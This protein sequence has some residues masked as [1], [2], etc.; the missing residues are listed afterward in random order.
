MLDAQE[1]YSPSKWSPRLKEDVIVG[2]YVKQ[3]KCATEHARNTLECEAN[4][5]YSDDGNS[6]AMDIYYPKSYTKGTQIFMFIHGGD[7][8]EGGLDQTGTFAK[9][10]T[11]MGLIYVGVSYDL[12]PD[13]SMSTIICQIQE[14]FR[15]LR[16]R[17][18]F[19][20][21]FHVMG[22]SAGAHLATMIMAQP[23]HDF[24]ELLPI[25]LYPVSGIFDLRPLIDTDL[26][27]ALK[28]DMELAE[29]LSPMN[30]VNFKIIYGNSRRSAKY[31]IIHAENDSPAFH[32]QS[33]RFYEMLKATGVKAELIKV[34]NT[35]HFDIV[36]RAIEPN[37]ILNQVINNEIN[38][39][40]N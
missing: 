28:L 15:Y 36:E 24:P 3:T 27:D 6:T 22:H 25:T 8:Q 37:F 14:A 9:S 16:H 26:N 19:T 33:R 32:E 10:V 39:P 34:E 31:K 5:R 7:W 1:Q 29:E 17:F 11:D 38:S 2:A 40:T 30:G 23:A 20:N 12:C 13:V 21:G 35:D 4:V 18:P